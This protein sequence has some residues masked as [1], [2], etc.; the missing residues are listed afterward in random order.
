V[1]QGGELA[2][3][4]QPVRD[5]VVG[6]ADVLGLRARH[7]EDQ[8]GGGEPLRVEGS[9]AVRGEVEAAGRRRPRH[10]RA[11]PLVGARVEA[12]AGG[13]V[14]GGVGG[15]PGRSGGVVRCR[16]L[17]EDALPEGDGGGGQGAVGVAH[18][19]HAHTASSLRTSPVVAPVVAPVV[20]PVVGR[21]WARSWA[22]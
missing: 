2:E 15:V 11:R 4:E 9:R 14:G 10:R 20:G 17:G 3:D 18:E 16:L 8:V 7:R 5:P 12:G 21:S 1:K 19:Q 13:G 6:H 22:A